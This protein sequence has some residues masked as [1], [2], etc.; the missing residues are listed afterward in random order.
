[1]NGPDAER[2]R[3]PV[4]R[5]LIPADEDAERSLIGA[6]VYQPD[7]VPAVVASGLEA[8]HFYNP[9]CAALYERVVAAWP[10]G[11]FALYWAEELAPYVASAPQVSRPDLYAARIRRAYGRRELLRAARQAQQAVLDGDQAAYDDAVRRLQ[12]GVA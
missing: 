2:S 9:A 10:L 5:S 3:H 11:V 12:G 7:N 6:L 8:G 4:V 1:M